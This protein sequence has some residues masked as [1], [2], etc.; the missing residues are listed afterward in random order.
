MLI[1]LTGQ[2]GAGKSTASRTMAR[3]GAAVIDAD[4]IGREAVECSTALRRKLAQAFGAQIID[5]R[6]QIRRKKL[7]ALAFADRKANATLNSLVHP[8]LLKELRRRVKGLL[9]TNSVVVIDAALL[10]YWDM[11]REVD[12]VLV[13]HASRTERLKRLKSK[14]LSP[15][16]ALARE[17]AQLP[18]REFQE[19]ADRV[20]LNNGTPRDLERKVAHWYRRLTAQID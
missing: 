14:G 9:R 15:D 20:I 16:K 2:I 13:I 5:A 6:G 1:G 19:R 11:D 12:F 8:Y 4:Q 10:L 7:A 17:R 18:Y 3:L